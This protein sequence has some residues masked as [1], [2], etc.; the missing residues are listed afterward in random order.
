MT[1]DE[2]FELLEQK[3][4]YKQIERSCLESVEWIES[5][6]KSEMSIMTLRKAFELGYQRAYQGSKN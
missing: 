1:E 3:I 2:E 5:L 4:K 6:T